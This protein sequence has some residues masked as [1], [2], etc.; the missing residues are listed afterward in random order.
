MSNSYNLWLAISCKDINYYYLKMFGKR[1]YIFG[2]CLP[3]LVILRM[4][5]LNV[6][7]YMHTFRDFF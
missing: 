3:Y 5:I 4:F 6:W 1:D 2:L 7:K